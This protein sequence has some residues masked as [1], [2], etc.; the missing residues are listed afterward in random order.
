[1][2]TL[3]GLAATDEVLYKVPNLV[4]KYFKGLEGDKKERKTQGEDFG[5]R[6]LTHRTIHRSMLLLPAD[7]HC[8][9]WPED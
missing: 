9:V 2:V 1:M 3:N 8:G 7:I 4:F 6:H 5:L